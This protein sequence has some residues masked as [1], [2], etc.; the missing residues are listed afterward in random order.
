[1]LKTYDVAGMITP[2]LLKKCVQHILARRNET[3]FY[4]LKHLVNVYL[5]YQ[6]FDNFHL[7]IYFDEQYRALSR[8]V[9]E[10]TLD[11]VWQYLPDAVNKNKLPP[12]FVQ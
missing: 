1:M 3:N 6:Y 10:Q 8:N 4:D 9:N 2:S 7:L 11:D 5:K 12:T